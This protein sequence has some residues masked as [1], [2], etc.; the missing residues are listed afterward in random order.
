MQT[1]KLHFT[2]NKGEQ[3]AARLILPPDGQCDAYALFAHCFTCSKN[4]TAIRHISQGLAQNRIGVLSFDF[5]GLGQSEGEF[6]DT[7]FSSNVDDLV[8]AADHLKTQFQEP[9]I[10]IGHSLGGAAVLQAAGQIASVAAVATIAAPSEPSH[11]LELLGSAKETIEQEGEAEVVLAG[12][13]FR[14]KKQFLDDLEQSNMRQYIKALRKPLLILHPVTDRVVGIDNARQIFD[15]AY[16]PKS[17]IS[18]DTADHLLSNPDDSAYVASL[19]AAWAPRYLK[20]QAQKADRD[21]VVVRTGSQGYWTSVGVGQHQLIAD[22]PVEAGGTDLGPT[23]YDY[24]L[25]ALGSCTSITLRMYADRKA[26]PLESILVRLKHEKVHAADCAQCET[27]VGLVDYIERELVFEGNLD[28]T[29]RKRL[30]EI[31]DKCPVHRTLRSEVA[32][33]TILKT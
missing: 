25:I 30:L 13:P 20:K 22:E 7:N 6:A 21:A 19:I 28:E 23:P 5:T 33:E 32:I 3:L 11:V 29:Q 9:Q 8:A 31:A 15:A 2:N 24:L 18:L 14:V 4:L 27:E 1:Q 26:W 16:H 10:L 17:F 12:R